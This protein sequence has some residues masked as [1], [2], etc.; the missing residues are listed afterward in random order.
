MAEA[1]AIDVKKDK[2]MANVKEIIKNNKDTN[3]GLGSEQQ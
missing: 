2:L 3:A 1:K